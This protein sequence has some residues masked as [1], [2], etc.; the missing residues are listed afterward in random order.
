MHFSAVLLSLYFSTT[1]GFVPILALVG[2]WMFFTLRYSICWNFKI[3]FFSHLYQGV[4][5]CS[6]HLC[7]IHE[8]YYS[9][10]QKWV[11]P[12]PGRSRKWPGNEILYVR[13]Q[14][15]IINVI[16]DWSSLNTQCNNYQ[17]ISLELN[18]TCECQKSKATATVQFANENVHCTCI[19]YTDE[20]SHSHGTVPFKFKSGHFV[21]W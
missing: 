17:F 18:K 11:N 3:G 9:I 10:H 15:Q 14:G 6:K 21:W 1:F 4:E 13:D 8:N 2:I 16:N 12:F 5:V 7:I 20:S 19:M